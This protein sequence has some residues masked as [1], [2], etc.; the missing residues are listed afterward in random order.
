[1]E[2]AVDCSHALELLQECHAVSHVA[3]KKG[4][5]ETVKLANNIILE[6]TE[7]RH[8]L[9][10]CSRHPQDIRGTAAQLTVT[11]NAVRLWC[12]KLGLTPEKFWKNPWLDHLIQA[13]TSLG[14]KIL[15][16]KQLH[17]EYE[18]AGDFRDIPPYPKDESED[19]K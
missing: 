3:Y 7:V 13:S 2:K 14:P 10:A 9:N 18:S 11:V 15:H 17:Q 12:I 5:V 4:E 1:M 8:L 19:D 16:L 6:I